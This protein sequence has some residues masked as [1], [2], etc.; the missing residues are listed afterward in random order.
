MPLRTGNLAS[1]KTLTVDDQR[2]I[3]L[4][5]VK[6]KQIFAYEN[7]GDGTII[8]TEIKAQASEAFLPGSLKKYVTP[9]RNEEL[10]EIFKGCSL[11]ALSLPTFLTGLDRFCFA[12]KSP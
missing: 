8:L 4:P 12:R 3:R 2:R 5:D 11:E 7:Y 6:P 10:L 1:M 9:E